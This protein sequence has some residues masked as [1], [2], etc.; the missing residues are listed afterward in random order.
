MGISLLRKKDFHD[1]GDQ[2]SD[3]IDTHGFDES[4]EDSE[5]EMPILPFCHTDVAQRTAFSR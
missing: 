2:A 5:A 1:R 4:V 3:W